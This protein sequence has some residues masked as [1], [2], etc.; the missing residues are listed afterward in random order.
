M[1]CKSKYLPLLATCMIACLA[2]I[3]GTGCANTQ[4][5]SQ[6]RSDVFSTGILLS[7]AVMQGYVTIATDKCGTDALCQDEVNRTFSIYTNAVNAA[8]AAYMTYEQYGTNKTAATKLLL[9]ITAAQWDVT[10]A[11]MA[12]SKK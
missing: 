3:M 10:K 11:I 5:A 12:A 6:L 1:K 4:K 2:T 8:Q 7:S 9:A